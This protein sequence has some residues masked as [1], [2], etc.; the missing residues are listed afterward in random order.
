MTTH[1]ADPGPTP[2]GLAGPTAERW[3][4]EVT[5]VLGGDLVVALAYRTPADGTVVVPVTTFG[6]YESAE[7]VTF[8]SSFGAGKKLRRIAADGR[9][10]L[11]YHTR[12]HGQA[13]TSA[14]VLVQGDASFPDRPDRGFLDRLHEQRWVRFAPPRR[15]GR[16]WDRLTREYHDLRVPDPVDVRR[17]SIWPDLAADG[18][19]ETVLGDPLPD[20]LPPRQDPPGGGTAPCVRAAKYRR[21]LARTRHALIGWNDADGYPTLRPVDLTAD[22]DHLRVSA[23][24]PLP[25]QRRAGILAHWFGNRMLGQGSVILTGWLD[26]APTRRTHSPATRCRSPASCSMSSPAP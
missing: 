18:R 6:M 15:R 21:R 2:A 11:A 9:V 13:T 24:D 20:D 14:Y 10:A 1:D 25:P 4:S 23:P 17:I 19:P 12:D 8:T 7:T 22:G 26:A 16:L 5:D 3:P